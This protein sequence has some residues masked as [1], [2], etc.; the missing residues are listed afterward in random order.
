[1]TEPYR[2]PDADEERVPWSRARLRGRSRSA[3]RALG[4]V[5][6]AAAA[7]S[8]PTLFL[9]FHVVRARDLRGAFCLAPDCHSTNVEATLGP[10]QTCLGTAHG[11]PAV[12][13]ALLM[14]IAALAWLSVRRSPRFPYALASALVAV[15]AA[16]AIF[17]AAFDL[18]HLFDRVESL[19]AERL[20]GICFLAIL[21][22]AALELLATPVLYALARRR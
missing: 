6:L 12:E 18:P 9:P 3:Q 17:Y 13:I 8:I 5:R 16:I 2:E 10:P 7:V 22:S 21:A 19:V 11:Q 20:A 4:F 14:L 1:V 15:G